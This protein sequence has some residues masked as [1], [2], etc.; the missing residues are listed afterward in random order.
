VYLETVLHG[1][2]VASASSVTSWFGTSYLTP[3]FAAIVA[4][5]FWGNYNTILVSLL[6]YLLV[7]ITAIF[8][9]FP[10]P[11]HQASIYMLKLSLLRSGRRGRRA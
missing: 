4:D 5:T 8:F 1:S 6:V 9:R 10:N 3:I 2:N 7:S 11:N